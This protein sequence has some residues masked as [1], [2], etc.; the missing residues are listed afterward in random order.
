LWHRAHPL[1]GETGV[2]D[3]WFC[4]AEGI[5][6][7]TGFQIGYHIVRDYLAR[8]AGVTAASLVDTRAAVIFA[9]SHYTP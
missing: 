9:G 3:E 6:H 1:L 8:H 7:S 5:P 4:G 2:Y